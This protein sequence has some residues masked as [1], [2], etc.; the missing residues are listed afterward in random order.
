MQLNINEN[1]LELVVGDITKETTNVIVNAANST[2]LGGSGVDGAIHRAAGPKLVEACKQAR[3]DEL[4]GEELPTG[5][6]MMTPGYNLTASH[7]IHTV[8]PIWNEKPD[9]QEELLAN[10]YRNSLELVK[11]HKL[12][13][14]SFPSISTGVYGYP[15]EEA[16]KIALQTIVQFL[17]E[18]EVGEVR[19]VL[20]SE[21]D[22]G[23][24]KREL[25]RL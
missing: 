3:E 18:N 23:V 10:C 24:Y 5:E 2:L 4:N 25:E 15:M 8:G 20:F 22:Y 6:V 16:A 7:V 12:E 19:M 14:I 11:V 17:E 9:L 13:S 1:Y 21:T